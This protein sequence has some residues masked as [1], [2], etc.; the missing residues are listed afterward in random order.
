MFYIPGSYDG[1]GGG[2]SFPPSLRLSP[3]AARI[4]AINS[5]CFRLQLEGFLGGSG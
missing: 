4:V 2:G 5:S 1:G 3:L